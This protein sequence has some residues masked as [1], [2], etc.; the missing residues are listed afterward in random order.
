MKIALIDSSTDMEL[1]LKEHE[2]FSEII[3]FDYDSHAF[4]LSK[5]IPHKISDEFTNDNELEDLQKKSYIY[6]KWYELNEI[7]KSIIFNDINLGELFYTEF[8]YY[9]VPILKKFY[10]VNKIFSKFKSANFSSNGT[11]YKIISY[12]TKNISHLHS[13]HDETK[14]FLNDSIKKTFKIG[15]KEI[16][17]SFSRSKFKKIKKNSELLVDKFF[18]PKESLTYDAMLVEFDPIKYEKLFLSMPKLNAQGLY[19]GLRRP[20][21][22]NK[23][24][25]SIF[26]KSQCDVIT[27][28]IIRDEQKKIIE[29]GKSFVKNFLN[30]LEN[31]DD[32]LSSYFSYNDDS[33]WEIIKNDFIELCK[34]R[35]NEFISDIVLI[36]E[37]LKKFKIKTILLWSEQSSTEIIT[38][39]FSKKHNI[40]TY[41]LQHGYYHDANDAFEFN[42][43]MGNVPNYSTK[44]IV[45][46][47]LYR[48]ILIDIGYDENKILS[49]GNPL[50]D[51]INY[52]ENHSKK[53]DY[54]LLA[55]SGPVENLLNNLSTN[56]RTKY[57]E[58]IYEICSKVLKNKK[59]LVIKL[60]PW[61]EEFF[62][63]KMIQNKFPTVKILKEGNIFELIKK[64]EIF[65][66][67]D[68]STTI[69]EAF[70]LKKPVISITVKNYGWKQPSIFQ[71]NNCLY[72]SINDFENNLKQILIDSKFKNK[73]I[74]QGE[75]FLNQYVSNL[76]FSSKSIISILKNKK[77][78]I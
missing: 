61:Q 9:L 47:E 72:T 37:T 40:P 78:K 13:E 52:L 3:V 1:F 5:K 39:K 17:I 21:I 65:L 46:G 25:F 60:H 74:Y 45:W 41:L 36:D 75:Q 26:K 66:T 20:A 7:S 31:Y 11:L 10:E 23:Q 22:W 54:V 50:F 2:N 42:N 71:N 18:H 24:S 63:T 49:L 53:K 57:N 14:N 34:K 48:K 19:L 28:N 30:D 43:F 62:P 58:T 27:S 4:L 56:L 32:L 64:S 70:L 29:D 59:D 73:L 16:S 33:F 15:K 38:L 6:A 67:F 69:L 12:F 35:M 76:G 68:V 55:T 77:N 44:T 8:H 51:E